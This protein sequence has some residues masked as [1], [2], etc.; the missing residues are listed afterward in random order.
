[1]LTEVLSEARPSI[2]KVAYPI[3]YCKKW[4]IRYPTVALKT[5]SDK[6]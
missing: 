2:Q 6:G 1:M 5:F 4:H 3:S